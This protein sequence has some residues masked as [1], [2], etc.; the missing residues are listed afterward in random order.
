MSFPFKIK[1]ANEVLAERGWKREVT[2]D[3]PI[4][5]QSKFVCKVSVDWKG[6]RETNHILFE[7]QMSQYSIDWKGLRETAPE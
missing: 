1:W 7:V 5:L 2:P 6:L 4:W 3:S